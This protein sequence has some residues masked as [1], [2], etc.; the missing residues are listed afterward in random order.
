MDKF[1]FIQTEN[2]IDNQATSLNA[3]AYENDPGNNKQAFKYDVV[4]F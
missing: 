1:R 4:S 3:Q 2:E